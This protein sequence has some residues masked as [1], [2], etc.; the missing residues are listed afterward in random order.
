ME[1]LNEAYNGGQD[2]GVLE[3]IEKIIVDEEAC[4]VDPKKFEAVVFFRF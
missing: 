1:R 4:P 3:E 2:I